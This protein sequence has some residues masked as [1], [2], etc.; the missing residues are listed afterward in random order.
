M[1]TLRLTEIVGNLARIGSWT[2]LNRGLYVNFQ[3]E[4]LCHLPEKI[5][6]RGRNTG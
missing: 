1:Y 2:V 4:Q 3:T 5:Q 6:K